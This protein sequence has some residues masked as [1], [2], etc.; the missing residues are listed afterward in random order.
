MSI[1][2]AD[3]FCGAGGSINGMVE[4]GFELILGA[5]HSERSIETVSA[6]Y[7]DADFLCTDINHYDMRRLPRTDVLWASV[8][9]TELSPAGG[10][11]KHRGQA[12]FDLE[13]LG[14][15]P[16]DAYERT[17]ACALDVI[18]A[19]EVHRYQAVIVENVIE[20]ARDWEL[21]DW[22]VE[23]MCKLGY[24]VQTVN[25]SAA[26]VYDE[27]NAPAPQ[28]RDRIYIVFTKTGV[29]LPDLEPRPPAWC[30]SCEKTVSG[31]QVWKRHDRPKI[32]KYGA[33]YLY[34]CPK[35]STVV[36]PY[37]LPALAALDLSDIGER[38]GDRKRP[39]GVKTTARIQWGLENLAWPIL[40]QV[41]GNTFE[42][43]GYHRAWS[44]M[45][46]PAMARTA[47]G[48]DAI[49]GPVM[50]NHG[51]EYDKVYPAGDG[52]LPT[53][54]LKIGDGF[55]SVPFITMLRA[56]NRARAIDEPLDTICTGRHHYLTSPPGS[57]YVKHFGSR[58]CR[59]AMQYRSM[60]PIGSASN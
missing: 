50:V 43:P 31:R 46:S 23:G 37:V 8:I 6:N 28:W 55:A 18:R 16:S 4:A 58:P 44:A 40:A 9:C 26:H 22:W 20:F 21:Y 32:G 5:N 1:T 10:N 24:N 15:V 41:A 17:R 52:P 60:S 25:V 19:T 11:R 48:G 30:T 45:D 7:R 34:R 51:H 38:I 36:E 53:R 57:F 3:L 13:E 56:H 35:D 49:C 12:Q 33:Q 42:R 14:H 47:T 29:P 27:A 59:L 54:T 39:L 2:F